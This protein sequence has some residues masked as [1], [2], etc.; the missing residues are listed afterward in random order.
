MLTIKRDGKQYEST[1]KLDADGIVMRVW[2]YNEHRRAIERAGYDV[3]WD[4]PEIRLGEP[5]K[6]LLSETDTGRR[7]VAAV[8]KLGTD[9]DWIEVKQKR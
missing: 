7:R 8:L 4:K 3:T 1:G 6:V 2:L 5:V 9:D